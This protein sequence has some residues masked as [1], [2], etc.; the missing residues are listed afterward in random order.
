MLS[1]VL[2]YR[3]DSWFAFLRQLKL[4]VV[5]GHADPLEQSIVMIE[6]LGITYYLT[7]DP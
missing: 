3:Y 1:V 6:M 7:Q 2:T 4:H 5:G